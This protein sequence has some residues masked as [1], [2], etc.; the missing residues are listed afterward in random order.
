MA[1][2]ATASLNGQAGRAGPIAA[3]RRASLVMLV[4]LLIEYGLGMVV[5]LYVKVPGGH[6]G[7]G[8]AF[9]K[10][11]TQGAPALAIH[12]SLGLL[13]V[14]NAIVVVVQAVRSRRRGVMTASVVGLLALVGAAFNGASFVSKGQAADSLAMALL[15]GLALLCYAVVPYLLDR[16]CPAAQPS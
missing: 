1:E 6:P 12:A 4:L 14:L 8:Q 5:N 3:M 2:G 11:I 15:T 10:A 7:I 9:G 16:R 13:L